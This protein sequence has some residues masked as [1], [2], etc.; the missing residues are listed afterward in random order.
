MSKNWS[1]PNLAALLL[2]LTACSQS[3]ADP[4]DNGTGPVALCND[5]LLT[6][7]I[8]TDRRLSQPGTDCYYQISGSQNLTVAATLSATPGALVLVDPGLRIM[9]TEGGSIDLQ[10]TRDNPITFAGSVAEHGSWDG[11]CFGSDYREST[12]D[13][14][15]IL[16][17]GA[18]AAEIGRASCRERVSMSERAGA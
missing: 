11:F 17:A 2:L 1:V 5:G 3:P 9:V 4:D 16:W 18:N 12:F 15:H 6:G 13:N 14:V 8:R 7:T 10:G